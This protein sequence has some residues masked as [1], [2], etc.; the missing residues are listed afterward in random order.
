MR[1]TSTY[2]ISNVSELEKIKA[3]VTKEK[4]KTGKQLKEKVLVC[5]GGGCLASGSQKIKDSF[6]NALKESN[7]DKAVV[8]VG[9]G[10]LGPC[11]HDRIH[12]QRDH[13]QPDR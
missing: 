5:M 9:T 8:V 10:C 1:A 7:L 6:E 12:R 11:A 13:G 4:E 3:K 2:K